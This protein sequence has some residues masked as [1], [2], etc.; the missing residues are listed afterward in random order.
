MVTILSTLPGSAARE[1]QKTSPE[2]GLGSAHPKLRRL[3]TPQPK[4]LGRA[5]QVIFANKNGVNSSLG[6][7]LPPSI[8]ILDVAPCNECCLD[9]IRP[10]NSEL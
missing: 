3:D 6:A 9:Q 7:R 8:T 2:V 1:E 10:S 5:H 4:P